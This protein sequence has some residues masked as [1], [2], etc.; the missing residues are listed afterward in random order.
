MCVALS[1]HLLLVVLD[2]MDDITDTLVV[3]GTDC[4]GSCIRT[5]NVCHG[6]YNRY[7]SGDRH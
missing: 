1:P 7:V 4:I 5:H 2:V 6:C 3:I